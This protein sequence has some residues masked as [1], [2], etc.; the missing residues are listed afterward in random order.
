MDAEY[1]AAAE[2]ARDAI[3]IRNFM[4]DLKLPEIAIQT[5]PLFIDNNCALKLTRNPEFHARSKYIDV[6]WHYIREKVETGE[7]TTAR[8]AT[9]DNLADILTKV[10]AR[11]THE[12][13]RLR[14]GVKS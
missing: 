12:D 8:V 10:L 13:L 2:A 4:N 6:K 5:V 3:W 11:P 9:K 14:M 1:I 7:I